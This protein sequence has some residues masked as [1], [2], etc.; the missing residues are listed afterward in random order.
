[1]TNEA[2]RRPIR[3]VQWATGTV[4]A[5]AMRGVIQ[6]PDMELVGVRVYSETKEGKDAGELCGLPPIGVKATRDLDAI[7]AL[8]PDCV[9]YMPESTVADDLC[10]L[11]E[12]GINIVTTRAEFFNPDMMD[13]GLR[14]RVE[15]ACRKGNASIHATGSSPGFITEALPIVATSLARQVDFL[16][17]EEYANCLEGCSVEMLTEIMGFGE[18]P[19]QFAKRD[20]AARDEVF[21]HSLGLIASALGTPI[22]AFET[23]T[24]IALCLHDTRLHTITI[25]AGSVGGQRVAVTGMRDGKPFMRFRSNW[26]VTMDL[27]PRWDLRGDGWRMTIEGDTPID[28]TINLP[29]P[30]E[31]EMRA[32]ARYTAHRPVNAIPYLVAAAPGIVPTTALGQVITKLR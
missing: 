1:M 22:D 20:I 30:I 21:E 16:A 14:E 27:D 5:F 25:P 2:A 18:T 29:M 15:A 19:E 8:R 9:L 24:E 7:V 3:V 11:L 13:L 31:K 12:N 32:S 26:F 17:I 6:H 23:T 4:G 28:T 10:R